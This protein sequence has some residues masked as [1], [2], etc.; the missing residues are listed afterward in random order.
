MTF[1]GCISLSEI[2]KFKI[3][4]RDELSIQMGTN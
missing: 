3:G 1:F 4:F 2:E